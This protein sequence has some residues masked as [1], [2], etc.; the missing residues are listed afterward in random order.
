MA[1]DGAEMRDYLTQFVG[2][3]PELLPARLAGGSGASAGQRTAAGHGGGR[4]GQDPA[5]DECGRDGAGPAGDREGGVADA[6]GIV[7]RE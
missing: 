7:S 4:P 1:Q 2:E 6:A 5:G 3:N